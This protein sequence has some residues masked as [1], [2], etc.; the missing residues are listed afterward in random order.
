MKFLTLS[1]REY[2]DKALTITETKG[3]KG[4]SARITRRKALVIEQNP[5][6]TAEQK[7]DP[8]SFQSQ[9]AL[10]KMELLEANG[11]ENLDA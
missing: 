5:T 6:S 1:L 10:A 4:D 7:R 11:L 8:T 3:M 2:L 9:A